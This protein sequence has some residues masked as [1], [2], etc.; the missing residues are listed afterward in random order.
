[1][2]IFVKEYPYPTP[3]NVPYAKEKQ[4]QDG[5]QNFGYIDIE[6][7]PGKIN[8][9]PELTDFPIFKEFIKEINE[10]NTMY[11]YGCDV[12]TEKIIN[13]N[14]V[15]SFVNISFKDD[16]LN[17]DKIKY[18]EFI[19]SIFKYL[20]TDTLD[21]ISIDVTLNPTQYHNKEK[22]KKG[23]RPS[24]NTL[25]YKGWSINIK[26]S[27]YNEKIEVATAGWLYGIKTVKTCI[28]HF[29]KSRYF[30]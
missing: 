23:A 24:K 29:G 13:E 3:C 15:W 27:S 4:R 25:E 2:L 10:N 8:N 26:I 11:T 7:Y 18:M 12:G 21:T 28:L 20:K 14:I 9:I 19:S 22:I 17:K 5:S 30:N 6:K 16:K 1:M